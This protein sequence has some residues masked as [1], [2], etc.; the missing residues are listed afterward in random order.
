MPTPV[1]TNIIAD[2]SG[3]AASAEFPGH[4]LPTLSTEVFVRRL[5]AQCVGCARN[6]DHKVFAAIGISPVDASKVWMQAYL[7][8]VNSIRE[9]IRRLQGLIRICYLTA[10]GM[11]DQTTL[12]IGYFPPT[13]TY[14]YKVISIT[15]NVV[16]LQ[17]QA[18]DL[19][20]RHITWGELTENQG[21]YDGSSPNRYTNTQHSG[22]IPPSGMLKFSAASLAKFHGGFIIRSIQAMSVVVGGNF[23]VTLDT[24]V[25]ANALAKLPG[26]EAETITAGIICYVRAPEAWTVPR[27]FYP[28]WAIKKT[29][30]ITVPTPPGIVTIEATA[31]IRVPGPGGT[32]FKSWLWNGTAWI[33][34]SLFDKVFIDHITGGYISKIDL[35]IL[36]AG[37]VVKLEYWIED[38]ASPA[39]VAIGSDRCKWST[40]D[41]TGSWGVNDG[42]GRFFHCAKRGALKAD[43]EGGLSARQRFIDEYK[44]ACYFASPGGVNN[45][46]YWSEPVAGADIADDP[47]APVLSQLTNGMPWRLRQYMEGFNLFELKRNGPPGLAALS[48]ILLTLDNGYHPLILWDFQTGLWPRL[49]SWVESGFS[50]AHGVTG[51]EWL[52]KNITGGFGDLAASSTWPPYGPAGDNY[53]KTTDYSAAVATDANDPHRILR[54]Q[55][56]SASVDF[57]RYKGD[58]RGTHGRYQR[59]RLHHFFAP[60]VTAGSGAQSFTSD[61]GGSFRWGFWDA[62]FNEQASEHAGGISTVYYAKIILTPFNKYS[63]AIASVTVKS[64]AIAAGVLTLKLKHRTIEASSFLEAQTEKSTQWNQGGTNVALPEWARINNY[65]SAL[66]T[67]GPGRK[68]GGLYVIA[69]NAFKFD[70][71]AI[72]AS[73]IKNRR[74]IISAA[75]ACVAGT[76]DPWKPGTQLRTGNFT[77]KGYVWIQYNATTEAMQSL[78]I[79]RNSGAVTLTRLDPPGYGKPYNIPKDSYYAMEGLNAAGFKGAWIMFSPKNG[80]GITTDTVMDITLTTSIGTVYQ[81]TVNIETHATYG[82]NNTQTFTLTVTSPDVIVSVSSIKVISSVQIDPATGN[83]KEYGLTAYASEPASWAAWDP[84]KYFIVGAV[85]PQ[86]I[87]I[88]YSPNWAFDGIELR[89]NLTASAATDEEYYTA[90]VSGPHATSLPTNHHGWANRCDEIKVADENGAIQEYLTANGAGA[91]DGLS[92]SVYS[93]PVADPTGNQLFGSNQVSDWSI[94]TAN[95]AAWWA[96]GEIYV[97]NGQ[98]VVGNSVFGYVNYYDRS[99]WPQAAE[100]NALRTILERILYE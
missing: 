67:T 24:P 42:A 41:H 28:L 31:R 21:W 78:V 53:A 63:G 27:D 68:S 90:N 79:K 10:Q 80:T 7:D 50:I 34:N 55:D 9:N 3:A 45:C 26:Q 44:P 38:N 29:K 4:Y 52:L 69:G 25:G 14:S 33:A 99:C 1:L 16:T 18:G 39:A 82:F 87:V 40:R 94:S 81:S 59:F 93:D 66:A 15:G 89:V 12:T 74:F 6:V 76:T 47:L 20:P 43:V 75:Q 5:P 35:S 73:K 62:N 2:I 11:L 56:G 8:H 13:T 91:F 88:K 32:F 36:S 60:K 19:N 100:L 84:L 61:G 37:Q 30:L 23:T 48:N 72:I 95:H 71:G 77:G 65:Q 97:K 46:P 58:I 85:G 51:Y 17:Y 96:D 64:A 57:H 70:N 54:A 92:F 22:S 86:S 49:L 98:L 83:Y